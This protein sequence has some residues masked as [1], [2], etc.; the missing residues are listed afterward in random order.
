M[1]DLESNIQAYRTMAEVLVNLRKII[2]RGLQRVAGET[3]YLDGC[4]PAVYERLVERKETELAIQRLS[5]EYEDLISFATFADLAEIV[6]FNEDLARLLRNLAP[7]TELLCARLIELEALRC[8]LSQGRDLSVEEITVITNYSTN[9]VATLAGARRRTAPAREAVAP[10]AGPPVSEEAEAP[11]AEEVQPDDESVEELR[12]RDESTVAVPI[13]AEENAREEPA[14]GVEEEPGPSLVAKAEEDRRDLAVEEEVSAAEAATQEQEPDEEPAPPI[15]TAHAEFEAIADDIENA[16]AD[17]EARDVLR[18]LRREVIAVA[19]AVYRLDDEIVPP[20]WQRIR[21]NG[22][23]NERSEE[24]GLEPLAE[25]HG[26]VE[27]Y[28]VGRAEGLD[29]DQLRGML[30]SRKFSRLL[31]TLREMFLRNGV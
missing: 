20:G 15:M 8:K 17:G 23:F 11:S 12:I 28:Q 18:V 6:E 27:E 21:T 14:P 24:F 29:Q 22:W 1:T 10:S 3:W 7:S 2:V 30:S 16:L 25:F 26:L 4:P 31:L 5:S 13:V 9:L 19:E